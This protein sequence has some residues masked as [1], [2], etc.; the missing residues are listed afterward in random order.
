[1]PICMF[2]CV[3]T[4]GVA[5]YDFIIKGRPKKAAVCGARGRRYE[6][7]SAVDYLFERAFFSF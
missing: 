3:Y 5:L 6:G 7:P 4:S 1:M 2:L